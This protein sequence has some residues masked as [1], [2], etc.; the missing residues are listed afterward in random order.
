MS[1]CVRHVEGRQCE[2]GSDIFR[3]SGDVSGSNELKH[4]FFWWANVE[5]WAC[6]NFILTMGH[7]LQ[8]ELKP[9]ILRHDKRR[10]R[11]SQTPS[12]RLWGTETK[13]MQWKQNFL[14]HT[15]PPTDFGGKKKIGKTLF[16]STHF[17]LHPHH[18]KEAV[19]KTQLNI[20]HNS[21]WLETVLQRRTNFQNRHGFYLFRI[22]TLEVWNA[23][24]FCQFE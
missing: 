22:L 17:C 15:L 9:L 4:I 8:S 19:H 14:Y 2:W 5:Y 7:W 16:C 21:P 24:K 3:G 18:N 13:G 10:K 20:I 11:L 23:P 6:H 1:S 12:S